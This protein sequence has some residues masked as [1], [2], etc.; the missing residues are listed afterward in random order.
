LIVAVREGRVYDYN[1]LVALSVETG[2]GVVTRLRFE[3]D[4]LGVR[5]AGRK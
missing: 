5:V 1:I 4:N 3:R 2:H